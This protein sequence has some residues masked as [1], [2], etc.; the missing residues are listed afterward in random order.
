[1]MAM[2]PEPGAGADVVPH[3]AEIA[4]PVMKWQRELDDINAHYARAKENNAAVFEAQQRDIAISVQEK[5]AEHI[6][7]LNQEI[8]NYMRLVQED[9]DN[10]LAELQA[11]KL[12][13]LS[14]EF[15]QRQKEV[16]KARDRDLLEHLKMYRASSDVPSD[17]VRRFSCLVLAGTETS[18]ERKNRLEMKRGTRKTIRTAMGT[19]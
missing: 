14:D 18:V 17:K 9:M 6:G 11:E 5:R 4:D 7:R 10:L 1:M 13:R 16:D 15:A 19:S 2:H 3:A 12:R 8:H